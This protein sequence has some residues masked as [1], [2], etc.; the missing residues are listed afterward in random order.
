MKD[1]VVDKGGA[2]LQP[3]SG[4][5]EDWP[6][7]KG[8]FEALLDRTDADL[9]DFLLGHFELDDDDEKK[10]LKGPEPQEK[11][12]QLKGGESQV[13]T[14]AAA[15]K[16]KAKEARMNRLL[17]SM[18]TSYTDGAANNLVEQFRKERDGLGAWAALEAKYE[19]KSHVQ[20]GV[21]LK[22]LID[23]SPGDG[24]PDV[25]I[26]R[27]ERLQRQLTDM[28]VE[29]SDKLMMAIVLSRMQDGYAGL[30]TVL[31]TIQDLDYDKLKDQMRVFYR[32]N[33][34]PKGENSEALFTSGRGKF[35]GTCRVCRERGHKQWDCPKKDHGNDARGRGCFLCGKMGHRYKQCPERKESQEEANMA[36]EDLCL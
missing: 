18:L 31:D 30:R 17:H 16:A 25:Y 7:F 11:K 1:D 3:F 14:R 15:K 33:V 4:R 19:V 13:E 10:L 5:P 6:Q 24:D 23:D 29:V 27:V 36:G 34:I 22:M 32:R 21:T 26:L 12:P 2:K 9:L 28:G 20:M 35:N 8:R